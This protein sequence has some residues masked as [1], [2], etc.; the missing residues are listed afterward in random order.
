MNAAGNGGMTIP[1]QE[2]KKKLQSISILA[3][4]VVRSSAVTETRNESTAVIIA[5]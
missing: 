5:I 2:R 4:I 3:H 1:R